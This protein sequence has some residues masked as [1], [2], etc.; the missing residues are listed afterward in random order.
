MKIA[1]KTRVEDFNYMPT[2]VFRDDLPGKSTFYIVPV[3]FY[4]NNTAFFN[5][6]DYDRYKISQFATNTREHLKNVKE[7][8]FF[9]GTD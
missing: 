6:K 3:S 2:W 9:K 5:L 4:E 7:N 8:D 1:E